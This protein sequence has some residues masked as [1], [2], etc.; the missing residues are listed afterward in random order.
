MSGP[1][2]VRIVTREE[3]IA[4]C[5]RDLQRL[6]KD[7]ARWENQAS[8]LAQLSDAE[9]AAAHARRASLHALL[10]QE[11]WLDVQLQVKIES[12]FLKRDLAE[13]E[14]RAIRQAAETRQQH[15]RLQENASALLQA[16]DARPDAASA[17]LRQTLHTLADGA[18]RD[19]AEALLAQGFAALASAPAEE[20][21]SEAQR[22]LAQRLKTDETPMSLE[23]WRARQQQDAPHEQRLARIDRHI[24]ELQLL[25]G[26]ASAQAFLERLARAEAEQHPERRNLLLDSLVLDLAQAARE[27]QQQ[28]QRLEHLQDLASEVAAL[29]AAEHAELLQRAACQPD[30]DPQQL[31]ELTERCNA[32]LTAHL[33]QQAALARRQAVLQGLASL[34]YEVRE[35]MATAWAQTGRVVLR[36]PAT[37]GYGLEVGGKADNGRLQL[38]AV[39]LNANRDSQ[40]D[41]DIETLWCGEFQRLQALLAAQGGELSV[42]RA[43]GVGEVALKEIGEEEQREMGVVRQRGL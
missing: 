36:K 28:R 14:E 26:E 4:T 32:I 18:L 23:Q 10:E 42:E 7:L 38:R 11:R 22:E 43:L 35:G 12:E 3:A 33:Q 16:L 1:K 27:H 25:Q 2:V 19:D 30:S 5:E 39:A 40:R 13:R 17:A 34:G 20:R 37:P 9:R 41:R 31:A 8:R 15:R 24:A 21:L 6:D 29:G